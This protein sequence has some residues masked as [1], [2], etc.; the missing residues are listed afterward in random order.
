MHPAIATEPPLCVDLDGTLVKTDMLMETTARLLAT[1]PWMALALPFWLARGRAHLK[2]EIASRAPFDPALLPYDEKLL[3]D[4]RAKRAAGR[5]LVL[6]TA[7]DSTVA[8]QIAQ[9]LGLFDRTIA[10]DG[11]RNLKGKAKAEAL[12]A[13]YGQGNFD[14]V[15][16]DRFDVP[17]W[18]AA[19]KAIDV[20]RGPSGWLRGLRMHQWAKNLLVFVP[21]LTAHR[22]E[23]Q[24]FA[25]AA[26][27][28]AAFSLA[29][30]CIYLVNDLA[31]LEADRRHPAKRGRAL[32]SGDMSIAAAALLAPAL[33]AGA[34]ALCAFLL[35]WQ[36]GALLA[37]YVVASVAYS[38]GIKRVVLLDVFVLAGLYL[39][40]IYAGAAAVGVPVSQWL[41][42]FSMFVFL[43]LALAKRHSEVA[44]LPEGE[45]SKVAGRG[46][47]SS[48]GQLL[49][50]LGISTGGIS[51]VVFA[52]YITSREVTT[53]YRHPEALWFIAP[54]LL[55]WIARIWLAALRERLREDPLLFTLRDAP[56]YLVVGA[57]LVVMAAAK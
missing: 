9:H 44:A 7:A 33:L 29:A 15:G 14:Y 17:V 10:S 4:L 31:D 21:L 28:F 42:A 23:A 56:S 24:A 12:V 48:D 34:I 40:R 25:H 43:S 1:R 52:L 41:L 16:N 32:A 39:L 11:V 2:R 38:L 6:A 18:K 53:L 35:P 36:F 22:F 20:G 46:Y 5:T 49:A 51:T 27:A 13:E 37:T 26:I 19:R 55:Y 57:I 3:A 54:L 45:A 47:T 8:Q 50:M 30:S